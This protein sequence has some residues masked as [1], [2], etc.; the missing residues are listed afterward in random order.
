MKRTKTAGRRI[1]PD[2]PNFI[3]RCWIHV[4]ATRS[5]FKF[6]IVL[7]FPQCHF[8]LFAIFLLYGVCDITYYYKC[9]EYRS[10]CAWE[11]IFNCRSKIHAEFKIIACDKRAHSLE[12]IQKFKSFI[13]FFSAVRLHRY[14][15]QIGAS[16]TLPNG[17][18]NNCILLF[19]SRE[20]NWET[21]A[22]QSFWQTYI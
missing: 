12:W 5:V 9:A 16:N 18:G 19:K 14:N 7:L 15:P 6:A 17:P 20:N 4:L 2:I 21:T 11:L 1:V 3:Q 8:I 22:P 10:S 13:F